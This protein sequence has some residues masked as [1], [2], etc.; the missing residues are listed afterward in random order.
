MRWGA[1]DNAQGEHP[2]VW[3]VCNLLAVDCTGLTLSSPDQ[4]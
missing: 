4:S 2:L 3:N 1:G